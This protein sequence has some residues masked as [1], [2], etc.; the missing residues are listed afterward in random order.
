MK[1]SICALVIFCAIVNIAAWL[2]GV[3]KILVP[4]PRT[5]A[6]EVPA[7][8]VDGPVHVFL[9]Q[10]KEQAE[11]RDYLKK[12]GTTSHYKLNVRLSFSVWKHHNNSKLAGVRVFLNRPGATKELTS[13]E[14]EYV[15]SFAFGHDNNLKCIV[16]LDDVFIRNE[17]SNPAQ[18]DDPLLFTFVPVFDAADVGSSPMEIDARWVRLEVYRP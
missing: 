9:L 18:L 17:R 14:Q 5:W 2:T 16:S 4:T 12:R 6:S 13:V 8:T 3:N 11:I 1:A 15:G 7:V 10:E